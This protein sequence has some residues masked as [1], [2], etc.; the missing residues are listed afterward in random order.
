[1][2]G[3]KEG[4]RERGRRRGSVGRVFAQQALVLFAIL[5]LGLVVCTC[6]PRYEEIKAGGL[7]VQV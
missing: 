2:E 1:M 5:Q 4:G 3:G 6:N 7:G